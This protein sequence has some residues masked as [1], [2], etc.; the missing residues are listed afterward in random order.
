MT[1]KLRILC[2]YLN[3]TI[4]MMN[5]SCI[6]YYEYKTA[7]EKDMKPSENRNRGLFLT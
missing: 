6:P 5:G 7:F 3:C 2:V 1:D 4:Y